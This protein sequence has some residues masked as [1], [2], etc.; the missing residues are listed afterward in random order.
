MKESKREQILGVYHIYG[1][2][3]E[4]RDFREDH[5]AQLFIMCQSLWWTVGGT[6]M[7]GPRF[8]PRRVCTNIRG[9]ITITTDHRAMLTEES[10]SVIQ[11]VVQNI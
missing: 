8:C 2:E 7:T 1:T 5:Y 10:P 3:R 9:F 6:K 11:R 4:I